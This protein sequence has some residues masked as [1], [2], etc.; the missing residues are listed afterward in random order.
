[1]AKE[2]TVGEQMKSVFYNDSHFGYICETATDKG[3]IVNELNVY[4]LY[5]FRLISKEIESSYDNITILDNN[6]I[7]ISNENEVSIYNLQGF[8]KFNYTFDDKIYGVIPGTT[9]KR[10]YL[11][12]DSKTEEIYIK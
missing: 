8:K 5:G 6:E 2:I 10:Y 3:E 4:N 11:I 1:M 9:S 7:Y 12:E